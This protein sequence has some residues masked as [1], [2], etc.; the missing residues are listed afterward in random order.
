MLLEGL[1]VPRVH[2]AN[3]AARPLVCATA[4][5]GQQAPAAGAMAAP[6]GALA[7]HGR[8]ARE[9]LVAARASLAPRQE[10]GTRGVGLLRG[11]S[12][13]APESAASSDQG[14]R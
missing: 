9:I 6:G 11:V 10:V 4:M 12:A 7:G 14:R 13:T 3:V 5:A 1:A 8:P 2:G